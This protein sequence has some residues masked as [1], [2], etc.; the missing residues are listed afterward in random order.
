MVELLFPRSH[1]MVGV[2]TVHRALVVPARLLYLCTSILAP[3]PSVSVGLNALTMSSHLHRMLGD[4][5][6]NI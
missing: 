4:H 5:I 6:G 2:P 3:L 1:S